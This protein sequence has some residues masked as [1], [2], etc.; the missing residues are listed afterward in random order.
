MYVFLHAAARAG[1]S[2]AA[3]SRRDAGLQMIGLEATFGARAEKSDVSHES[4]WR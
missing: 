1:R 2:K 3:K 4:G